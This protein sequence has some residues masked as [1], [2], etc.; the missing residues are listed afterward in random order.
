MNEEIAL[1][2]SLQVTRSQNGEILVPLHVGSNVNLKTNRRKQK[3][4][5][6]DRYTL[7]RERKKIAA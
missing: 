4:G 7:K 1:G 5:Y 3:V 2:S 6:K